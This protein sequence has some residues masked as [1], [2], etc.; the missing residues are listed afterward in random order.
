MRP[1]DSPRSWPIPPALLLAL[2]FGLAIGVSTPSFLAT[3][4][5]QTGGASKAETGATKEASGDK[6]R[7]AEP[8]RP[9][10]VEQPVNW[11]VY[12]RRGD[13]HADIPIVLSDGA[14]AD[15]IQ[16][17]QLQGGGNPQGAA[18]YS[19]GVLR[20]V[21]VG[22]PYRIEVVLKGRG[23]RGAI[24]GSRLVIEPVFVGDLWVLAGQSNMQ[25][26]GNLED[27]TPPS[28]RVA[29]LGM[30]GQWDRAV[31]PLHWLVDSPDP[32]HH[33]NPADRAA[34]SEAE[35]KTRTKGAGLG[36][37]FGVVLARATNV[38]IGLIA[39]A[40][41]GTSMA[42]WDPA[43]KDEGGRSLYGSMIRQLGLAGNK[44]RGVL[45]YQGESDASG[46]AAEAFAE[47]FKNFIA[48]VRSDLGQPALPFYYVQ[49]GRFVFA[50]DPKGW[51][52]VQDA[53]RRIADEVPNT[54]VVPSVDLELDDLIH[55]GTQGLKRL[56]IRLARVALREVYGQVG[57]TT[58][59]LDRVG[60]RSDNVLEVRFKGV[61]VAPSD[62]P[63]L[64]D[65]PIGILP[66]GF[67]GNV[68]ASEPGPAASQTRAVEGLH[69]S[70]HIAG[71]SIRKDDG[72]EIPLIF[73]AALGQSKDTVLL[74][75]VGPVPAGANLWYGHGMDPVC[76]LADVL[77]M[78]VPVFGPIPLDA[79]K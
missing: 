38:P 60:K 51:N 8:A 42:Q 58:P 59:M 64:D 14:T 17:V 70:R 24:G 37:P 65:L 77:D 3:A 19:D 6:S 35:H 29:L 49:I 9:I 23:E 78:A 2:G 72:T 75:L 21:P 44:V 57:A 56:G 32:V 53:Q 50:R 26:V 63:R 16:T 4:Q 33:G 10:Q 36:L 73:D 30:D 45:W 22:G 46:P 5:A 40:H 66:S 43:K 62:M 41:G 69:P 68:V 18:V 52:M 55:V 15:A 39:C 11:R 76:N 79:R 28:D 71:F 34:R 25:G 61:N 1:C 48:A 67:P 31:E 54:A 7:Q 12:Q 13:D 74:K 20:N 27:V 47:N